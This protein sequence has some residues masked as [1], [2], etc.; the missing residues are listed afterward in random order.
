MQVLTDFPKIWGNLKILGVGRVTK[1]IHVEDQQNSVFRIVSAF[2]LSF[3]KEG[4]GACFV[5]S[6][7]YSGKMLQV[8][9]WLD[10]LLLRS[11]YIWN[12]H[13]LH[14]VS[15]MSRVKSSTKAIR[16]VT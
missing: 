4:I 6:D 10:V 14:V 2:F 9:C 5:V 1:K 3:D 7:A 8:S 16:R 15:P 13:L 11:Q 12:H